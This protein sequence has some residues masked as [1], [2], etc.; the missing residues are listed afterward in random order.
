MLQFS[1]DLTVLSQSQRESSLAPEAPAGHCNFTT[2]DNHMQTQQGLFVP[3]RDNPTYLE[4]Q[5]AEDTLVGFEREHG[6][7]GEDVQNLA[8][9]LCHLARWCDANGFQL[10]E[11]LK[12]AATRYSEET[13][14]KGR[15]LSAQ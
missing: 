8:G 13:E 11:V 6:E 14:G 10:A 4:N 15:Q 3:H 2:G 12:I 9:T 7:E 5:W 1:A